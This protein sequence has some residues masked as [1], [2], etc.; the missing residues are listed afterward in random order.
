MKR[1]KRWI[2][3]MLVA[4]LLLLPFVIF[5]I[6]NGSQQ[7]LPN[8]TDYAEGERYAKETYYNILHRQGYF[9]LEKKTILQYLNVYSLPKNEI[10]KNIHYDDITKLFTSE[11][12]IKT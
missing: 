1:K 11:S 4:C 2:I 6:R 12:N 3:G 7:A 8:D 9:Q 10:N 5:I